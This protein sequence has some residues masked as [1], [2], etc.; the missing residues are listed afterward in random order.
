MEEETPNVTHAQGAFRTRACSPATQA[1]LGP[2]LTCQQGT[3]WTQSWRKFRSHTRKEKGLGSRGE[4]WK[5]AGAPDGD[6]ITTSGTEAQPYHVHR[7]RAE[8]R[9]SPESGAGLGL[10]LRG[11]S[12]GKR[13]QRGDVTARAQE[14]KER[15]QG[16]S[17]KPHPKACLP[18][19]P[20]HTHRVRFA[21]RV[22]A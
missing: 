9:V 19:L 15:S 2:P 6:A 12:Q 22:T 18:R 11:S 20:S 17:A 10:H 8:R 21:V 1:F 5:S 3:S 7:A 16:S 4:G 13:A 14:E